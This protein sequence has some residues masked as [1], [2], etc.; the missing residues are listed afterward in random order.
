MELLGEVN[1]WLPSRL[2]RLLPELDDE[3]VE[4]SNVDLDVVP[5]T[6]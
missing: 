3:P 4:A 5:A 1:R 2:D 6:P